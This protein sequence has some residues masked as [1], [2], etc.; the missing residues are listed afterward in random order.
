MAAL[1]ITLLLLPVV[2][3]TQ[4]VK[5]NENNIVVKQS[6]VEVEPTIIFSKGSNKMTLTFISIDSAMYVEISGSNLGSSTVDKNDPAVFTLA[7]DK[8]VVV[9][10]IGLQS[11][12]PDLKGNSYE[13]KYLINY[14]D[15]IALSEYNLKSVRKY[16][17]DDFI[18]IDV[19]GEK[20][21][22]LKKQSQLFAQ[23]L[24]KSA[25]ARMVSNVN[26]QTIQQHIGD[27]VVFCGNVFITRVFK[28]ARAKATIL[29]F[30]YSL[31]APKARA[32]IW[33]EDKDKFENLNRDAFYT[34][35]DVCITGV[36]Y[37]YDGIPYIKLTH[38]RQVKVMPTAGKSL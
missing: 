8:K 24:K 34:K 32:I 15:L 30:Q 10:S 26:L 11:F 9:K 13:H 2:S 6:K 21:N 33:E 19:T 25:S 5:T 27:S 3:F 7:N 1:Y 36:V 23:R 20:A 14:Q 17:F 12:Q 29:D 22:Q 18:D 37:L 35:K 4:M 38:Q 16:M 31:S 28:S